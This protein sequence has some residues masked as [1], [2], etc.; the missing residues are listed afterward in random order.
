MEVDAKDLYS[1]E[2][3]H[4][5]QFSLKSTEVKASRE[6]WE[7]PLSVHQP[8]TKW[9]AASIQR[10]WAEEEGGGRLPKEESQE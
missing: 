1:A 5:S 7:I 6:G 4:T 9:K 2:P 3:S 10:M 8:L